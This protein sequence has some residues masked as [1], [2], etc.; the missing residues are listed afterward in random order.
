MAPAAE[1]EN[2]YRVLEPF[3]FDHEGR[4]YVMRKGDIVEGDHPAYIGRERLFEQVTAQAAREARQMRTQV[5]AVETATA[6]PG[7]R[8][9]MEI[10]SS[11]P[12]DARTTASVPPGPSTPA[13]TGEPPTTPPPA[14]SPPPPPAPAPSGAKTTA[15]A[16]ETADQPPAGRKRR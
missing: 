13:P 12:E 10:D 3:A 15:D 16:V 2:V 7:E 14:P 5:S 8:R 11:V 1:V 9:R 4:P 6:A